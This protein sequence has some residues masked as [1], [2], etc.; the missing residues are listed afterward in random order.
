MHSGKISEHFLVF[1]LQIT[2]K[3]TVDKI[4]SC[5]QNFSSYPKSHHQTN[6]IYWIVLII[7]PDKFNPPGF[8]D[9][10]FSRHSP[11]IVP[12]SS[13]IPFP[14]NIIHC[15]P[16]NSCNKKHWPTSTLP[17]THSN[18]H[19]LYSQQRKISAGGLRFVL[20]EKKSRKKV[21]INLAH[22]KIGMARESRSLFHFY[23]SCENEH[24]ARDISSWWGK[25]GGVWVTWRLTRWFGGGVTREKKK[26]RL[27][28]RL[29]SWKI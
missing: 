5:Y 19:Y 21:Y 8:I 29:E 24:K 4:Q 10:P 7:N 27:L 3:T 1:R 6:P 22:V 25:T 28:D 20:C 17:L 16:E 9:F 15:Q 12:N 11:I 26:R 18:S 2:G 23:R 13:I 14:K